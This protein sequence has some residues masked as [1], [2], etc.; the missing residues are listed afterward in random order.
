MC[1]QKTG[2]FLQSQFRV[3]LVYLL[4]HRFC[5]G[6]SQLIGSSQPIT[7][8]AGG[9]VILPC[10]LEPAQDVTT[11]TLEWTRSD[12]KPIIIYLLRAGQELTSMKDPSYN[13]RTSLFVEELKHGN[14]S[15]KLSKVKPGDEGTYRCFIPGKKEEAFVEL[16]VASAPVSSPV[17]RLSGMDRDRGGVV[18]QCESRGWYPE[19]EVLW[20]DAEG[21]LLSAGP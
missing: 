4:L 19:P 1:H 10:H 14:I 17:I 21:N 2:P 16:V 20:L 5:R 13:G 15:L 3:L 11:S 9:D 6:Q 12:L 18:L 7:A 8:V